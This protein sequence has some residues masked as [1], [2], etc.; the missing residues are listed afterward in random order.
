MASEEA[1]SEG[2]SE[3][4]ACPNEKTVAIP[5]E[6]ENMPPSA[7]PGINLLRR[8]G[9]KR[10]RFSEDERI[11]ALGG[12][13]HELEVFCGLFARRRF[14]YVMQRHRG[15]EPPVWRTVDHKLTDDLVY[16]HL[17]A[18][19]LPVDP[20]WV[21]TRAWDETLFMAIDVDFH[22]DAQDFVGRCKK[23]ERVLY[24]LG[25]PRRSWLIQETPSGGRH[26]YVFFQ[27]PVVTWEINQVLELVNLR[28]INGQYEHYPSE[29]QGLR[30]PFGWIPG[31]AHDP[32]AWLRFIR[33]YESG[34]FPRVN[35]DRCRER[36]EKWSDRDL[37][38][39]NWQSSSSAK[40]ASGLAVGRQ[41]QPSSPSHMGIPKATQ[42]AM[43]QARRLAARPDIAGL[44]ED[45]IQATGTRVDLTKKLAWHFIFVRGISEKGT[46]DQLIEWVYR[47]GRRL[48]PHATLD[49]SP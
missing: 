16:R 2:S 24:I 37:A 33:S 41:S 8:D 34:E 5:Q 23:V 36:A 19:H 31:T 29:T 49:C 9:K 44:L 22:G 40:A 35:W 38:N 11:A 18:N 7:L 39:P 42:A 6:T 10:Q 15:N 30:L 12:H 32:E 43:E 26:Y 28:H 27:D 3:A 14:P 1:P 25:I 48:R 46:A 45:G 17:L 4:A 13:K 47:T 20:I 21:G